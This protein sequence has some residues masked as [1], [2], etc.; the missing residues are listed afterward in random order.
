MYIGR[1]DAV[2]YCGSRRKRG[3]EG[4]RWLGLGC[5]VGVIYLGLGDR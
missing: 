3:R 5:V 4:K 1:D 2:L